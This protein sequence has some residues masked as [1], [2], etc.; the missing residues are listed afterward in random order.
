MGRGEG[1]QGTQQAH[2]KHATHGPPFCH[3]IVGVKGGSPWFGRFIVSLVSFSG[4]SEK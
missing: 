3:K 1:E 2:S 4:L